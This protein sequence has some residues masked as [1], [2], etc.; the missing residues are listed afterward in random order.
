MS[1][2]VLPTLPIHSYQSFAFTAVFLTGFCAL[3]SQ[4]IWQKY[5]AILTGSEARSLSLV[6][7]VFLLGLASGYYVFG[8][9]TENK[10]RPRF[11]LLKYYGYVELITG[12]YI[13]FFPVYFSFLKDFSFNTPP[14]LIID[15][16]VSLLALFLPTFLMGAGIPMLTAV[17][18][19]SA[20]QVNEIHTKVYG[21]NTLGACL[22]A[23]ISGFYL[24]PK[25]GLPLSLS[26]IAFLNIIASLVFIGNKLEGDIVKKERPQSL[27]SP[28]PNFL[29]FVFVF[30]AGSLT[31]SFE[32]LF[33]R[34][35]NLSIG[36]GAYNF[37]II[38]SLFIGALA[39]GSLSLSNKKPNVTF[40]IYQLF[41]I[42][43]FL[44]LI[45]ETA[46]YWPH[47]LN[48]IRVSLTTLPSN[49]IVWYILIFLFLNLF[50][51]PPVFLM[52]RLLPLSYM[53]IKKNEKNYGKVCGF[54]YFSNTLGTVFGSIVMGYL[55]F[56]F[57]DLDLIFKINL[58]IL[59]LLTMV[60]VFIQKNRLN[61]ILLSLIALVLLFQPNKWDRSGHEVGLFRNKIF[62]PNLHF[63]SLLPKKP[64][65]DVAFFKDGP[66]TTVSL[67]RYPFRSNPDNK[68]F[69][70]LENQLKELLSMPDDSSIASYS[71][72]VN[73]K[74][75]GNTLGD[76]STTFFMLPYLY[77]SKK[78]DLAAAFIGLGN[79]VSAGS[80]TPL[81]EVK[82]IDVLEISPYVIE[83]VKLIEPAF[84]FNVMKDEKVQIIENDAFKYFTKSK[85]KYD[86]IVSEPS[87]PW[88]M[89][90][91]NL[92]TTEFYQLIKE[93]LYQDG[94]FAQWIHTYDI[95]NFT[96]ELAFKT[97]F[98]AFPH[99]VLYRV[100]SGDILVTASPSPLK[101]SAEKFKDAFV[102]KIY[103]ALGVYEVED[104][105]L[106]QLLNEEEFKQTALLS[107]EAVNSLYAPK[108]IY[109]TNKSFFLN[110][111]ADMFGFFYKAYH[112]NTKNK[113]DKMK[114][115]D[116]LKTKD[117]SKRCLNHNGFNF[118]CRMTADSIQLYNKFQKSE[119]YIQK[120]KMYFELRK[121]GLI[122]YDSQLLNEF[123]KRSLK[124]KSALYL[125]EL[126]NELLNNGEYSLVEKTFK[127]FKE[128]KLIDSDQEK[129]FQ[130]RLEFAFKAHKQL[131]TQN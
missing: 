85:K 102:K 128:Q 10:N 73:G 52:G 75:D 20:K 124:N 26:A 93:S 53:F 74:S 22:G 87:N 32:I 109:R 114:A 48:H 43:L 119:N 122:P 31:I 77:S 3:C 89:G 78:E 84:N 66:N 56:Y 61:F 4:V 125:S 103:S 111:S 19:Q 126:I 28:F 41:L 14:F 90:V 120:T 60:L 68:E 86:I 1:K 62:N 44:L 30:T 18:P 39:C 129:H 94:V 117:W 108:M 57:F 49:Y 116:R 130:I 5:L 45:F 21:W 35:L 100:G 59:L 79:G 96:L 9:L 92:Y 64:K 121:R 54:L 82:T 76:F 25:L 107:Y 112:L 105:Y 106:S 7:A 2:K 27:P 51:F 11:L 58:Y 91:E 33:I 99:A 69:N 63:K 113:T 47:W 38:L 70:K 12:A 17:L 110:S 29:F 98:S 15:L 36:A 67:L 115:F 104:I 97:I 37:P 13:G 131:E 42:L 46:P 80:Y 83:A 40:L 118:L 8:L 81:E 95:N 16:T 88:V 71:I 50:L 65:R 24:I 34:I 72:L 55:A 6:I 23:L 101:L 127:A 123:I